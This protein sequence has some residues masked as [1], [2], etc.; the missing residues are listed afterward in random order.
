MTTTRRNRNS[1]EARQGLWNGPVPILV[2]GAVVGLFLLLEARSPAPD[3]AP[4]LAGNLGTVK[5][6]AVDVILDLTKLLM[7]WSLAVI[8]AMAYFLKSAL[9]GD[10]VLSRWRL[11]TAELVILCSVFSLFFG[12][13]VFNSV[14]NMLALEIFRA[15]DSALVTY[16]IAQYSTFLAAIALFGL[17]VHFTC[18][19]LAR[20]GTR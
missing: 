7:T 4:P 9:E 6:K 5:Q 8:G 15:Q 10:T 11:V 12:H 20:D 3:S 2:V 13:L 1:T 18:W 16:G 14:I 17:Y 19:P